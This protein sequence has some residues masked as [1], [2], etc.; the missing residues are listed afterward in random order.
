MSSRRIFGVT[1]VVFYAIHAGWQVLHDNPANP[2]WACHLG[3]LLVG[4]GLLCGAPLLNLV[5]VLWLSLGTPLW[6]WDLSRG[7]GTFYP[8]STLTH[9]G[10]L[11]VGILGLR[12]FGLPG[13]AAWPPAF[14]GAIGLHVLSRW[15]APAGKHINFAGGIW[16]GM[17]AYFESETVFLL[18]VLLLCGTA[19]WGVERLLRLMSS[20]WH[21]PSEPGG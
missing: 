20:R 1:A 14:G 18:G 19:F 7:A 6:I 21:W 10:G 4:M 17:E 3:S 15:V 2:L 13:R 16:P 8:T 11:A 5:G 12:Q 9:V